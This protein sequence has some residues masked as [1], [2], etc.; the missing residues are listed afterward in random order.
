MHDVEIYHS[1]YP[2]NIFVTMADFIIPTRW[3]PDPVI[4][5]V[6][7]PRIHG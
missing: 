7:T 6:I 1:K 5:G 2:S 3:A 4:N